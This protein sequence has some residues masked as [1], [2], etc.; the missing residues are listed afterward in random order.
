MTTRTSFICSENAQRVIEGRYLRKSNGTPIETIEGMF[1][2]VASHIAQYAVYGSEETHEEN[3]D[4]A[5]QFYEAMVS[6]SFIPNSPTFTGA[7]TQLQ[8]LA[9]CFVLPIADDLVTGDGSIFQ[10]MTHA[11]AIQQTGGGNGFSFGRLREKDASVAKSGGKSSGPISFMRVYNAAFGSVAQGG[12]RRGANMAI[13][14]VDHPDIHEFIKCKA[15]EGEL[16]NFNISVG[17]T[18]EFMHAVRNGRLF[19]LK[20][21]SKSGS[22]R[23]VDARQLFSEIVQYA[24]R[25]GEPGCVFLDTINKY[26]PVPN[27][28][29]LEATNPCVTAST[30][31]ETIEGLTTVGNLVGIPCQIKSCQTFH[32]CFGFM[33]TGAQQVWRV[34]TASGCLD[35]TGAHRLM[36]RDGEWVRVRDLKIGDSLYLPNEHKYE[37]IEFIEAGGVEEVF[38]ASVPTV[39]SY[40]SGGFLSHNCGEQSLGPYENCCLGSINL[41]TFTYSHPS[42]AVKLIDWERLASVIRLSTRFL[43]NVVTVNGYVDSVPQLR[44]AAE[45]CRRIGLGIM[46]LADAMFDCGIRYG[47][48]ESCDFATQIM[49]YVRYHAMMTSVELAREKGPFLAFKDSIYDPESKT[50]WTPPRYVPLRNYGR[51][52]CDWSLVIDGIATYGIRNAAQTTIAPTGTI[53]T[54]SDCEGYGCEP[55]FALAYWRNYDENGVNRRLRYLS[56]RFEAALIKAGVDPASVGELTE[57]SCQ[58]LPIPDSIKNVFVVSADITAKEHIAIQS[59]LQL[60]VDN[61]ISKT[62]NFPRGTTP[63]EV[64]TAYMMAWE[65][66]CKGITVYVT[67]SRDTVVLETNSAK[68][69]VSP[70]KM[71]IMAPV[72]NSQTITTPTPSGKIR[73]TVTEMDGTPCE[74][75]IN[76]GPSG[77][78]GQSDAEGLARIISLFLKTPSAIT[79]AS[80]LDMVIKQL[81]GIG[82]SS[83]VGLGTRKIRSMPD[84]V[85]QALKLYRGPTKEPQ[86]E[87]HSGQLCPS[88]KAMAMVKTEGCSRCTSCGHSEC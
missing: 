39:N 30:K 12:T 71:L 36:T 34:A 59:A 51:P 8:Q 60:F 55:V 14:P 65:S 44:K 46:G 3:L 83:S 62:C 29:R 19:E 79:R 76:A 35:A 28:Y 61:A 77:T 27:L 1:W 13:L 11:A 7:G 63:A 68:A 82:G 80:R 57:G 81:N 42:S 15:V 66:G 38:D 37:P 74:T 85:A 86:V 9:A 24:H 58:K 25:N 54:I 32:P 16:S 75:F 72:V 47:S 88:C 6:K 4:L 84:G 26:N 56:A 48:P 33:S 5:N 50:R 10:T 64:E 67:G 70:P 45:Q 78:D 87:R 17:I 52:M 20:S 2:R 18:D 23:M 21:R 43:D 41:G 49:E 22:S 53:A 31:I 40:N 69:P 73:V